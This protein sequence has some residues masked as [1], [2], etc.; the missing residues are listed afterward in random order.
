M[1]NFISIFNVLGNGRSFYDN[2]GTFADAP[3]D[4]F[5]Y[6]KAF[7]FFLI[8]ITSFKVYLWDIEA[9]WLIGY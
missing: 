4:F 6:F 5:E 1:L 2:E 9:G 3:T 7:D 8:F